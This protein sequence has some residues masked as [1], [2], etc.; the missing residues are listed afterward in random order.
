MFV[1][2]IFGWHGMG[3]LFIESIILNDVNTVAAVSGF[4]ASLILSAGCARRH[5][6]Y[7]LLDPRGADRLMRG[8]V[9]FA[10]FRSQRSRWPA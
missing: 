6:R 2:E 5:R 10:R 4:V 8:G 3:E 1:E 9:V 7:A